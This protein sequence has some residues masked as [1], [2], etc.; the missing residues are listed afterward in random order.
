MFDRKLTFFL[1]KK[2]IHIM[3]KNG[4]CHRTTYYSIFNMS[5]CRKPEKHNDLPNKQ[6]SNILN[7][8]YF[9]MF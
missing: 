1:M 8:V 2:G 7:Y 6:W 3:S 9:I 5:A 4:I